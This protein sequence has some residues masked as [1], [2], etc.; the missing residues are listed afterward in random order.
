[1][2]ILVKKAGAGVLHVVNGV[3]QLLA[4]IRL[5][6]YAVV[7]DADTKEEI[8]VHEVGADIVALDRSQALENRAAADVVINQVA[9]RDLGPSQ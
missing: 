4:Q 6:G 1:M 5:H 7:Q 8:E 3:H 2:T 9:K